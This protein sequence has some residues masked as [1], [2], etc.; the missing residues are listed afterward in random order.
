MCNDVSEPLDRPCAARVAKDGARRL[1]DFGGRK[2][3][4]RHLIQQRLKKVMI[5]PAN[6]DDV[7]RGIAQV[8]LLAFRMRCF[9]LAKT[10]SMGLRSGE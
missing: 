8:A 2:R 9:S 4:S 3:R 1:R 6:Q 7:D 5:A 10:Y